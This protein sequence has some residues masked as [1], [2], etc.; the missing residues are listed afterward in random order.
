[1][2]FLFKPGDIVQLNVEDDPSLKA[3]FTNWNDERVTNLLVV[4][5]CFVDTHSAYEVCY[6]DWGDPDG[7]VDD[8]GNIV[9]EEPVMN[10]VSATFLSKL[11]DSKPLDWVFEETKLKKADKPK[12]DKR[13]EKLFI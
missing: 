13:Y 8:D 4:K 3:F 9:Y 1:M 6:D 12:P 7:W 10:Y 11:K 5:E 2:S